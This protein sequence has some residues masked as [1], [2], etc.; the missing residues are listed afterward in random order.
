MSEEV[1]LFKILRVNN[2]GDRCYGE[3]D[4]RD[5][6]EPLPPPVNRDGVWVI[7]NPS[8]RCLRYYLKN[9]PKCQLRLYQDIPFLMNSGAQKSVPVQNR[10]CKSAACVVRFEAFGRRFYVLLIDDKQYVQNP[11]GGANAGETGAM[12]A[13]REIHEELKIIVD[14]NEIKPIG[15]WSVKRQMQLVNCKIEVRSEL[16]LLDATFSQV[17]HLIPPDVENT[18]KDTRNVVIVPV[19]RYQF[20]L[21]ETEYVLF[22]PE[23]CIDHV[24]EFFT[25]PKRDSGDVRY[26]NFRGHHREILH[27]LSK[28]KR[29]FF[30]KY[31]DSFKLYPQN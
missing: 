9:D 14:P 25:L 26:Y 5:E 22:V 17:A 24:D 20:K 8:M 27:R 15:N 10:I 3:W 7:E 16:F 19:D 13:A 2:Y 31:L 23:D 11:Q 12:T 18:L 21:D 28:S 4:S 6:C 29:R 30:T 1:P